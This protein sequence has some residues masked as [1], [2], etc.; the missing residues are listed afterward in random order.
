MTKRFL[1][2]IIALAL[3]AT[4]V[5]PALAQEARGNACPMC[6]ENGMVD[7]YTYTPWIMIGSPTICG[8]GQVNYTDKKFTRDVY[9]AYTCSL[10]GWGGGSTKLYKETYTHCNATGR[11]YPVER[12]YY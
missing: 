7:K 8:H 2:A 11:D 1:S 6:G 12:T 5:I 3:I 4:L 9:Y 10:C